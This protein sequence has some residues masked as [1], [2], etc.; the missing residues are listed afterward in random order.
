MKSLVESLFDSDLVEKDTGKEWLY[1]LVTEVHF[2]S[3]RYTEYLAD[4]KQAIKHDFN[5]AMKDF[6]PQKWSSN[7][8]E[9]MDMIRSA[10]DDELMREL[11]YLLATQISTADALSSN[12]N[13]TKCVR[14]VMSKY[15]DNKHF[16]IFVTTNSS[17]A[18]ERLIK[19]HFATGTQNDGYLSIYFSTEI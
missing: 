3:Q 7:K 8:W 11:V 9:F 19:V 1:A 5:K 2:F 13:L 16:A 4:A 10:E 6:K 15:I 14:K 17:D 18:D 12:H